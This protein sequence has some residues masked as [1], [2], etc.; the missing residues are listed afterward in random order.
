MFVVLKGITI[1]F[2]CFERRYSNFVILVCF[3]LLCCGMLCS[4]IGMSYI[5][6]EAESGVRPV[7]RSTLSHFFQKYP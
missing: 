3:S 7:R 5:Y 2:V 4:T 1:A 6:Y